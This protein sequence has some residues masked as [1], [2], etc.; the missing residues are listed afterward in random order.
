MGLMLS[1]ET[2]LP[3][4]S[5]LYHFS[6]SAP[7]PS[8]PKKLGD[9]VLQQLLNW[10]RTVKAIA[11][12]ETAPSYNGLN[13]FRLRSAMAEHNPNKPN[14]SKQTNITPEASLHVYFAKDTGTVCVLTR[15]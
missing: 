2:V 12:H 11:C 14:Q 10:F 3:R 6:V 7:S 9:L 15:R 4:T 5:Q 8:S 1:L 13:G